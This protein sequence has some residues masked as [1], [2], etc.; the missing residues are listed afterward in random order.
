MPECQDHKEFEKLDINAKAVGLDNIL[1]ADLRSL[2]LLE[3]HQRR[4]ISEV[5]RGTV[6]EPKGLL[7]LMTPKEKLQ[8]EFELVNERIQKVINLV[9]DVG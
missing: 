8:K 3:Q 2:L 4:L 5:L 1:H 7:T 6:E 9:E